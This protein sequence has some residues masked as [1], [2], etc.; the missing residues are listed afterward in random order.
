MIHQKKNGWEN[1]CCYD[2]ENLN[3]G[4]NDWQETEEQRKVKLI[5]RG[6]LNLNTDKLCK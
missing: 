6:N 2:S 5:W 3:Q 1:Q 4:V